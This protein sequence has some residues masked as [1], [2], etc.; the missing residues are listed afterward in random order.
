M[1]S[2]VRSASRPGMWSVRVGVDDAFVIDGEEHGAVE[3]VVLRQDL[4]ELRQALLGTVLLVPAHQ[5][6]P[7]PVAGAVVSL[8]LQPGIG[9]ER[10]AGTISSPASRIAAGAR[11]LNLM[12]LISRRLLVL[13]LVCMHSDRPPRCYR[14]EAG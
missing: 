6:D 10:A 11:R 8:D 14:R 4:R 1:R 3:P 2:A 12:T 5:H 9:G 13:F 7:L